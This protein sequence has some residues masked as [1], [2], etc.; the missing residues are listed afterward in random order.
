VAIKAVGKRGKKQTTAV[1]NPT[2]V[3]D[4]PATTIERLS[5]L[6][7]GAQARNNAQQTELAHLRAELAQWQARAEVREAVAQGLQ[8]VLDEVGARA[9]PW[10]VD[11]VD[12]VTGEVTQQ[13]ILIIDNT[14]NEPCLRITPTLTK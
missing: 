11:E 7:S 5:R 9:R 13:T 8:A 1:A 6:I 4:D 10:V 2:A 14:E 12:M 3:G